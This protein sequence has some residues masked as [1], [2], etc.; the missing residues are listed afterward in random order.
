[1][2]SHIYLNVS[3]P[4]RASV[5]SLSCIITPLFLQTGT[6]STINHTF[7]HM[8]GTYLITVEK[9]S[10]IFTAHPVVSL[11]R[12]RA[13]VTGGRMAD[14]RRNNAEALGAK[15]TWRHYWF[16]SPCVILCLGCRQ[17]SLGLD[18][19]TP[20]FLSPPQKHQTSLIWL[21]PPPPL[22]PPLPSLFSLSLLPASLLPPVL[23]PLSKCHL[24]NKTPVHTEPEQ[25][26]ASSIHTATVKHSNK[27]CHLLKNPAV[28]FL[29]F[30]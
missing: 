27:R 1:M 30:Y 23:Q 2:R 29:F 19:L 12:V 25:N 13:A 18:L 4:V 16:L 5:R 21:P 8:W 14:W 24:A 28:S 6:V 22:T 15:P 20:L 26:T 7:I 11:V 10:N 17:R 3:I 9:L